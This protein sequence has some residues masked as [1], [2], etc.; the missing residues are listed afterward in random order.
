MPFTGRLRGRT[1]PAGTYRISARTRGGGTVLHIVVV[2]VESGTPSPTELESA[3]Q[4]NVCGAQAALASSRVTGTSAGTAAERPRPSKPSSSGG[5]QRESEG[6]SGG[7]A[8]ASQTNASPFTPAEV[9]KHV[10]NPLV[11]AALAAAVVLLGVAALPQR[12][13]PDAR[14]NDALAHHRVEVALAG[15]AALTAAIVALAFS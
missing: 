3:R 6:P 14:L 4:S 13:I 9:A 1:L 7:V 15:A 8:G 12:A 11:I 2:V 5:G 10:T